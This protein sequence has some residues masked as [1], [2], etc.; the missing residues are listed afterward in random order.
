[1]RAARPPTRLYSIVRAGYAQPVSSLP[2]D[3]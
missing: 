2:Q 1:L 3:V